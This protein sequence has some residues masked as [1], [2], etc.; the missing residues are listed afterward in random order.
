MHMPMTERT[1]AVSTLFTIAARY[2]QVM[3]ADAWAATAAWVTAGIA[4]VTVIVAGW[5][6]NRQVKAALGQIEAAREAQQAQYTQAQNALTS[7]AQLA[8][9]AL[10]HEAREAQKTRDEQAQP[11]VVVYIE[12]NSSVSW[13]LELVVKNFGATPAKDVRL[14][15]DPKPQVSPRAS[16]AEPQDLWYPGMI[17]TLAPMQEW[18]TLW[19]LPHRRFEFAALPSWHEAKATYKDSKGVEHVTD[20]VLDWESL[21]GTQVVIIK[22]VHDIAKLLERQN[23][24]LDKITQV[25]ETFGSH[26]HGVWVFGADATREL[27]NRN[28]QNTE[29]GQQ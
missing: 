1:T 29:S 3:R 9:E 23:T 5:F 21:R 17:P 15:I 10:E 13:V 2:A 20:S 28:R 4:F 14:T 18:R 11:N 6:A 12:Q 25:L 16:G 24:K 19:D 8:R 26:E 7:Q 22:T 27:D